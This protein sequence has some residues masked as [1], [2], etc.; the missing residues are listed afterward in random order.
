MRK[1]KVNGGPLKQHVSKTRSQY[2]LFTQQ[3]RRMWFA[4]RVKEKRRWAARTPRLE[5]AEKQEQ[6][7]LC[8]ML[9]S[10]LR[11]MHQLFLAVKSKGYAYRGQLRNQH[12]FSK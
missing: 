2:T 4:R 9:L 12:H 5:A 10:T 8:D 3:K 7:D 6:L 1:R 11:Q